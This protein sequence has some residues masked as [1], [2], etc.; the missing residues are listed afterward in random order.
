MTESV[1]SSSSASRT[2]RA[3]ARLLAYPDTESLAQ[4]P[5]LLTAMRSEAALGAARLAQL[6]AFIG[7]IA[8]QDP[9]DAEADYVQWFDR[10]RGTSLYLFEHV[11]GD[12]R[13]RGPAMIDLTRSYEQSGLYLAEGEMPDHLPVV[14]EF[15]SSRPGDEAAAFLAEIAHLVNAI[16]CALTR[17]ES[18]YAAVLGAILDL[19]GTV[20]SDVP[21]AAE[22]PLDA[23]WSEPVAFDGCGPVAGAAGQDSRD[24]LRRHHQNRTRQ[25]ASA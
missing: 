20:E 11:H 15:A 4:W 14:L 23:A 2:L 13:A 5:A 24:P 25:E 1:A 9:L 6:E 7:E 17:R 3:L 22:E 8:R 18:G 19:A 12:S 10:G 21:I 16:G